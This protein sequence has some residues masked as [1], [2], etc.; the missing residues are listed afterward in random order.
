MSESVRLA[1][2]QDNF[3]VGDINGNARK[4][5]EHA[6]AAAGM[7]SAL[8]IFPELALTGYPPEDLLFRAGFITRVEAAVEN[9]K[10]SVSSVDILLGLPTEH[11]GRLYNS[12]VWLRDGRCIAEYHKR[13]LPNYSVFDEVRYFSHGV[14]TCVVE[15]NGTRF[16][17]VICED[18]W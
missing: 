17:V 13:S 8:V 14:E 16:G 5:I 6:R 3:P 4:I 11:Q 7:G 1:M 15:L 9:I 12:A 18:A 2:V 10:K